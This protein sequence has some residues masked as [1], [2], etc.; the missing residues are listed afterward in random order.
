MSCLFHQNFCIL[1]IHMFVELDGVLTY[2]TAVVFHRILS[3]LVHFVST[4]VEVI[5]EVVMYHRSMKY[6]WQDGFIPFAILSRLFIKDSTVF[7]WRHP[8]WWVY[9]PS[10][11]A[12]TDE[13]MYGNKIW[14]ANW[15]FTI[16]KEGNFIT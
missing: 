8:L 5:T 6:K 15:R 16:R 11:R 2:F 7:Y 10:L 9:K 13:A 1:P 4:K 3:Q 12:R 14:L